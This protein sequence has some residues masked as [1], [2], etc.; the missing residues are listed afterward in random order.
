MSSRTIHLISD[1]FSISYYRSMLSGLIMPTALPSS[2]SFWL[3]LPWLL[4]ALSMEIGPP[5]GRPSFSF[6]AEAV[7]GF[8]FSGLLLIPIFA[9]V[10][11]SAA[12]PL[13]SFFFF[14]AL[15]DCSLAGR[16]LGLVIFPV[17]PSLGLNGLCLAGSSSSSSN[18]SSSLACNLARKKFLTRP[19]WS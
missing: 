7:I 19:I 4:S 5:F 15:P 2:F 14:L 11:G 12:V 17:G 13:S 9:P 8:G 10:A 16:F 6:V 18:G 1:I 3:A